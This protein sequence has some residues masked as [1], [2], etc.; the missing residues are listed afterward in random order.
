M[1]EALATSKKRLAGAWHAGP[2]R[3][4]RQRSPRE[5]RLLGLALIAALLTSGYLLVER[6]LPPLSSMLST[7]VSESSP[8]VTRLPPVTAVDAATW[9][10]EAVTRGL[11]LTSIEVQPEGVMTHGEA[12][13]PRALVDF[14]RWA[15]RQGWWALD[16]T[17]THQ[18][19]GLRLEVR[20]SSR[21]EEHL[22]TPE[23]L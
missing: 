2:S 19:E 4:L 21:P 17:L 15:A 16:W 10:R 9:R 5:R 8:L 22:A 23:S 1:I 3:L 13:S 11:V 20:W 14:A 18:S 7:P 6:L 12:S